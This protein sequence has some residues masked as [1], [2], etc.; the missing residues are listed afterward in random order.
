MELAVSNIPDILNW[1]IL[2]SVSKYLLMKRENNKSLIKNLDKI[3]T[4]T[5]FFEP[6]KKAE[7]QN[8]F[9]ELDQNFHDNRVKLMQQVH[10]IEKSFEKEEKEKKTIEKKKW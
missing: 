9:D 6:L 1:K 8:P 5:L 3:R 10:K 4:Y 2:F 7:T